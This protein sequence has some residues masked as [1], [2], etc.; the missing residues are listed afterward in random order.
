MITLLGA[1]GSGELGAPARR[2]AKKAGLMALGGAVYR[3]VPFPMYTAPID[4]YNVPNVF[5]EAPRGGAVCY[6][7]ILATGGEWN[8]VRT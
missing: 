3:N 8:F 4:P 6:I 1:T 2:L 5:A 7:G